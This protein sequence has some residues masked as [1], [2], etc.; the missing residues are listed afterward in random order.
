MKHTLLAM[1]L[2]FSAL[3]AQAYQLGFGD[4]GNPVICTA[5]SAGGGAAIACTNSFYIQQTYGDVAGVIDLSY[6]APRIVTD[7]RSLR[8]WDSNYNDL[9]GVLWAEGGDGNSMARIE[10]KPTGGGVVNLT[11]FDLGAYSNATLG[12]T[13][14]VFELG[15]GP[16]L[17]S[18]AGSVGSGSTTHN[19]FDI[20]VSS[21]KGLWI[22]W[23]DS[24]Y[25]VGIDNVTFTV[26]AVP[27]PS[28]YALMLAGLIACG[29]VARRRQR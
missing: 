2:A 13:V 21:S 9:Y 22:E 24:A 15:G 20:N 10:L 7:S 25:N 6:S 16:A 28:T 23:Q 19:S 27:E 17:F 5:D 14:N 18:Y 1:G 12:T 8:W 26:G 11:H 29:A 4:S 3:G